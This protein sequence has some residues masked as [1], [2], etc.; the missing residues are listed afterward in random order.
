M[1]D[2]TLDSMRASGSKSE[3]ESSQHSESESEC[4]CS[5]SKLLSNAE[6]APVASSAEGEEVAQ[7]F[8]KSKHNAAAHANDTNK[9]L[10]YQQLVAIQ[11]ALL[12]AQLQLMRCLARNL[13]NLSL[14]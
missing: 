10:A 11:Q 4:A 1:S 6:A 5:E 12:T 14:S 2:P 8:V 7:V 9:G 3:E 13:S